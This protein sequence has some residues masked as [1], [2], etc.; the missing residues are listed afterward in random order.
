MTE[1][2]DASKPTGGDVPIAVAAPAALTGTETAIAA[3]MG[4]PAKRAKL[5]VAAHPS[6]DAF[7]PGE[8][9]S[10]SVRAATA[11]AR[12]NS[13]GRTT[14]GNYGGGDRRERTGRGGKQEKTSRGKGKDWGYKEGER[15]SE[16]PGEEGEKADRLPKKKVAVLIGYNGIG[17]SG[18]QMWVAPLRIHSSQVHY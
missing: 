2:V 18:S 11:S 5:N 14:R 8:A 6:S 12:G 10:P 3:D 9:D 1:Q 17:Y 16:T 13:R 4:T 7:G 15:P